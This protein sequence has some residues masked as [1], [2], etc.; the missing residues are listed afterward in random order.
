MLK[1]R[2]LLILVMLLAAAL[3]G[4]YFLYSRATG[5]PEAARLLPE[6]DRLVYANLKPVRLFWDL[7]KSKP[8]DLEDSYRD[9]VERTG[10]QFE[11]DLDELAV[12]WA[13]TNSD[14]ESTAIFSGRFDSAKLKAYLEKAASQSESYSGLTIYSMPNSGHNV[15]VSI[16]DQRRVATSTARSPEPLH[17]VIER[18]H[19]SSEGEGPSLLQTYYRNV[20]ATSLAWMIDRIR[21]GSQMPTPDMLPKI[22]LFDNTIAVGSLRYNGELLIRA[23]IFAVSDADARRVYDSTNAFL[24]LSGFLGK[25][26]GIKD[27]PDVKAALSSIHIEQKRNVVTISAECSDKLLKKLQKEITVGSPRLSVPAENPRNESRK[28]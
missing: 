28:P 21:P 2:N 25:S 27:G 20:P 6:G 15:R 18:L 12:S 9:F 24:A 4:A 5:A 8:L 26:G 1:Y 16:L 17:G 7:S 13:D 11:R 22:N 23:D 3:A 14:V 19:G 10:I